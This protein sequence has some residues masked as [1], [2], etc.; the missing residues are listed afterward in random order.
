[1]D[2]ARWARRATTAAWYPQLDLVGGYLGFS[3]GAGDL[4]TEW[5][6]GVRLSYPVFTG[7]ARS[8]AGRRSSAELAAAAPQGRM[9]TTRKGDPS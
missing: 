5:Q 9:R 7:G 8:H 1:M 3:G 4:T 2:A 6:A